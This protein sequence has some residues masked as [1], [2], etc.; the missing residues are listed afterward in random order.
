L[1]TFHR[2]EEK[3]RLSQEMT[4]IKAQREEEAQR[5][6][7]EEE[8]LLRDQKAELKKKLLYVHV[9]I[10]LLRSRQAR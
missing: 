4:R 10:V 9:A 7:I 5:I 2:Q 1:F 8:R 6:R 3:E